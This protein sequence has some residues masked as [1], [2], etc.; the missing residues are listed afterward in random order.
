MMIIISFIILLVIAAGLFIST[1]FYI[2]YFDEW[3]YDENG[4]EE[5]AG[6]VIR[7]Y[8]K[9]NLD[10]CKT[11]KCKRIY[12]HKLVR[13]EWWDLEHKGA[14]WYLIIGICS[15]LLALSTGISCI[16]INSSLS[17]QQHALD[18]SCEIEKLYS[19]ENTLHLALAGDLNLKVEDLTSTYHVIVDKPIE[20][21]QTIDDYNNDVLDL[22]K[23]I[24]IEKISSENI[25]INWFINHG[26]KN[27]NVLD[28]NDE[29]IY[30]YNPNATTYRD[31]LGNYLKTFNLIEKE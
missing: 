1:F 24:Y 22:K 19:R 20:I 25:W 21:K 7:D 13:E 29:T 28:E 5:H 14:I 11:Y 18:I 23:S 3:V 12:R 15:A 9:L 6:Y 27:V 8:E 4:D 16:C 10:K 17:Q 31:V 26:F 2:K 30:I